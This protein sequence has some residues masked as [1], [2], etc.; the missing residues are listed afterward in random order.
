MT[1]QDRT[2]VT[3]S[4]I[5][6]TGKEGSG[7]AMRW[8]VNGYRVIIGS[9]DAAKAEARAI[10]LN[11]IIGGD[12]IVGMDNEAAAAEGHIVVL[13]VP[14]SAHKST[15]ESVK[16]H[17][18]GKVLVDITVPLMPPK[19]RQ[20]HLP[21]GKSA[22]LEAQALLGEGVHVVSAFQNVSSEKIGDPGMKVD[23][24]V[25]ITGDSS[26][27]KAEVVQLVEAAGMRGIDAGPLVNSIA[28]EALT[29]VM[30]YINKQY[31]VKGCGIRV[32]GL[33]K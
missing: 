33:D 19:V 14:Y 16:A 12:Y 3:V 9:R 10:E 7:L 1:D 2:I 4:I 18:Q 30:L 5:G 22:G 29:P 8:A 26:D 23:C 28:V 20:V 21:E 31:G 17:L 32:T 27:A 15:L 6:G 25:L 11:Q 13:T 24:D